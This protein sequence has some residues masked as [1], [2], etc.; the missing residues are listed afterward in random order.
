MS[1]LT[2][3]N[4]SQLKT[5]SIGAQAAVAFTVGGEQMEAVGAVFGATTEVAGDYSNRD[6]GSFQLRLQRNFT[7]QRWPP[8]R[9]AKLMQR[10]LQRHNPANPKPD[11]SVVHFV[12]SPRIAFEAIGWMIPVLTFPL[13]F[14][15][16]PRIPTKNNTPM[17]GLTKL[18]PINRCGLANQ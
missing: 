16:L 9:I 17:H 2:R 5:R 13:R 1:E 15:L 10:N 14:K 6:I 11:R 7:T 4:T 18:Q 3:S 12:R 8:C